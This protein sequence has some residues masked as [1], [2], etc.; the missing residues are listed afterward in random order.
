MEKYE[1]EYYLSNYVTREYLQKVP[2][3]KF[4]QLI[5]SITTK[6]SK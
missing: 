6:R 4:I 3:Y 1:P 2:K 5:Q